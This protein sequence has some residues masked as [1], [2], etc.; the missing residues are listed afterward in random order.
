LDGFNQFRFVH[1]S[2]V[3]ENGTGAWQEKIC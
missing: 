2:D 1:G 3:S